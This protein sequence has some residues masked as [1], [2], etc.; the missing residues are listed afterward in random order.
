VPPPWLHP[1][2]LAEVIRREKA[3][4]ITFSDP[5][6][7]VAQPAARRPGVARRL[8]SNEDVPGREDEVLSPPFLPSSTDAAPAGYLPYHWHE[9]SELLL[10]HAAD[11]MAALG[12]V[13]ELRS[14][15]R[16]LTEV[17]A[18]KMRAG[19]SQLEG[20]GRGGVLVL[21]GVGAM[22]LAENRGFLLGVMDGLRRLGAA[23]EAQ[24]REEE[25]QDGMGAGGRGVVGGEEDEEEVEMGFA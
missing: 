6:P 22:E 24:R 13:S 20:F 4:A 3:D 1:A 8:N 23:D 14:L 25:E 18:A 2:S 21:R 15:L 10:S 17:R 12:T 16:D 11:D 5:P 9:L 7:L 19:T